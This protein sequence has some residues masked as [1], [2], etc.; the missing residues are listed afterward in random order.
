MIR[1]TVVQLERKTDRSIHLYREDD[2]RDPM[3]TAAKI[4][5]EDVLAYMQAS[6]FTM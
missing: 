6:G 1:D 3:S 5:S 2:S 4:T